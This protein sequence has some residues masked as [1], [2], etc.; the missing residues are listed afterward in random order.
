MIAIPKGSCG[1][2]RELQYSALTD[3]RIHSA[4]T[5]QLYLQ[6][7]RDRT[8]IHVQEACKQDLRLQDSRQLFEAQLNQ[9]SH[10]KD[11]YNVCLHV[12]SSHGNFAHLSFGSQ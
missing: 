2:P 4:A 1:H 9:L 7:L 3:N 8:E 6:M 5:T 12:L 10:L 11:Q